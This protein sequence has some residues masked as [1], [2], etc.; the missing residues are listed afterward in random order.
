MVFIPA[1]SDFAIAEI[2][3]GGRL[4][5]IGNIVE[6]DFKLG[7]YKSGSGLAIILM[8]FVLITMAIT[9]AKAD[10]EGGNML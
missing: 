9:S 6:Q 10:S 1:I 2:L 3:G 4:L 5:L 8:A 7:R